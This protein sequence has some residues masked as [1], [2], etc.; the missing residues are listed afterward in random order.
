M[1]T[2]LLRPL[3][4]NE[5]NI[6]IMLKYLGNFEKKVDAAIAYNV[7]AT[8]YCGEFAHLNNV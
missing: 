4:G 7:A 1:L 3:K 5:K 6:D 2:D 8:K